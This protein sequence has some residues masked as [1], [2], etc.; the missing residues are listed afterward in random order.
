M[1]TLKNGQEMIHKTTKIAEILQVSTSTIRK[2]AAAIEKHNQAVFMRDSKEQR[3]FTNADLTAFQHM[4]KLISS[5]NTMEQAAA[6][7]AT[8]LSN[9]QSAKAEVG[10]VMQQNERA[11]F[12][13][14]TTQIEE[15]TRQNEIM[16]SAI[17]QMSSK[18]S[19]MIA[20]LNSLETT[21]S[22]HSTVTEDDKSNTSQ[23]K[24]M[25]NVLK[26]LQYTRKE[27]RELKEE[28]AA[29]HREKKEETE[30]K[31]GFFSR[32]FK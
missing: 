9:E 17:N 1:R 5:G 15:L 27:L 30:Q 25:E 11:L 7:T 31:K 19:H 26:E 24:I 32:L 23:N 29:S 28:N 3:L 22:E 8:L 20:M 21:N 18:Q 12:S 16:A 2:Y 4:R 6:I 14:M 13:E 10:E